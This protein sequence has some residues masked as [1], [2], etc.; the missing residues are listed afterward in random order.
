MCRAWIV[1]NLDAEV[2]PTSE[3]AWGKWLK[4]EMQS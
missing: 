3:M 4:L 2:W 1:V